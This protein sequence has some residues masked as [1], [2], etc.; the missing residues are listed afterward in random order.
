MGKQENKSKVVI[1]ERDIKWGI[2][3]MTGAIHCF[4]N[5]KTLA[6]NRHWEEGFENIREVLETLLVGAGEVKIK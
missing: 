2:R 1:K 6:L 3:T 5:G 4:N